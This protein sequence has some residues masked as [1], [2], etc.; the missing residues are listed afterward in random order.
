MES[1]PLGTSREYQGTVFGLVLIRGSK[2]CPSYRCRR[3][4]V[5]KWRG[6]LEMNTSHRTKIDVVV[7]RM[8]TSLG[9]AVVVCHRSGLLWFAGCKRTTVLRLSW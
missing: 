6:Q 1:S 8:F 2:A 9:R 5:H 3:R 7:C 4:L